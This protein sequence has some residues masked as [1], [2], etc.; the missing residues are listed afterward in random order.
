MTTAAPDTTPVP[1]AGEPALV[2][3]HGLT[4]LIVDDHPSF[5]VSARRLLEA[6]GFDVVGEA[7][8]GVSALAAARMLAPRIVVLDVGLPDA[9]GFDIATA[10]TAGEAPPAVVL[11]SSRDVSDFGSL[12]EGS[13]ARGFVQKADLS[14]SSLLALCR[15][16]G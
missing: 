10:L 4:V 8:D 11:V 12:V 15:E 2:D 14:G 5:R 7:V 13:G 3:A 1:D 16:A 6:E 9:D